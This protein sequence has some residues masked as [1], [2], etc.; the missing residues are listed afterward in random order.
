VGQPERLAALNL[1]A[2]HLFHEWEGVRYDVLTASG[3]LEEL[4]TRHPRV[5]FVS[6]GETDDWAHA[7]RYDRYLLTAQQN[8]YFIRQLWETAQSLPT[9][10]DKTLFLITTDHGRGDGREGWKSHGAALPG[11]ERIWMAALGSQLAVQGIDQGGRFQQA[12]IAA[13]VAQAL[14]LDFTQAGPQ[15]Q[16]PLPIVVNVHAQSSGAPRRAQ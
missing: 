14:G 9:Y 13:T 12:Q 4:K 10:Q 8:D 1:V 6:L 11:S 2:S 3:A 15:I 16:P 7:G 5:L